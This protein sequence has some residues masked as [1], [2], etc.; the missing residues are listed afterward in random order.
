M[1]LTGTD[2]DDKDPPNK[3][4]CV[5]GGENEAQCLFVACPPNRLLD[6]MVKSSILWGS[7]GSSDNEVVDITGTNNEDKDPKK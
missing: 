4:A 7:K 2:D 3:T 6:Q 1:D 5:Q